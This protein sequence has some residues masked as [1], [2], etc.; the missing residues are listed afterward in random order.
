MAGKLSKETRALAASDPAIAGLVD[1]LGELSL[2]TRR[3]GRPKDD[4]FGALVRT[5]VAQ[6]VSAK[7]A[8]RIHE[9]LLALF[10]GRSPT[11][12]E[13]LAAGSDR[14]RGAGLSGRKVE[15]VQGLAAAIEDGELD[16][17][18]VAKLPDEEVR[19]RIMAL[20]GFGPWSADM[21]LI[22][23]LER[24]D[25]LPV[26][27]FGIRRAVQLLHGLDEPPDPDE[28]TRLAEPWR[29]RRSLACVYLWESL[30]NTLLV[31]GG[32][33]SRPLGARRATG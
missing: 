7:A 20:R 19:E 6:Q 9:R 24:P 1:R 5:V 26:G 30:H 32:D 16:L 14:L 18:E 23:S 28:L 15:Y 4:P 2:A 8:P 3:R 27:D 11:P 22:F 13:L 25:V 17:D 21:F 29:P 33:P 31:S 10:D 12:A